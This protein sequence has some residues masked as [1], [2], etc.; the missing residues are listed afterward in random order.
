MRPP[1]RL[2]I[3]EADTSLDQTRAKYGGY[4]GVF[5]ALLKADAE[6]L[7]DPDVIDSQSGLD[8]S[9]W[10]VENNSGAFPKIEDIDAILITG[11]SEDL[12]ASQGSPGS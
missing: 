2:A 1:I 11:S 7:G 4:G 6:D 9:L 8:V 3:L 12:H 5:K 10:H